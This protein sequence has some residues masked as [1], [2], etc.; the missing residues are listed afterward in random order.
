MAASV[1]QNLLDP[2][3]LH[4][5]EDYSL[6][7]RVVV[8]GAMPGIHRSLRQGRGS[9]FYQYRP[10]TRGEDLK[11][12]DWKV[13]AKRDELVSKTFQEST[14]FTVCLVMDVSASMGYEGKRASCSKLRYASMLAA[15]FSYLAHRQGDRLGLFAYSDE[16]KEWIRPRAGSGQLNRIYSALH[17]LEAQGVNAH[18]FGWDRMVSGLPGR[19]MVVFLSDFLE[20]E[21][22]LAE[23]LRFSL[24]SRYETLCLQVLDPDEIDLP[25]ADAL[26]FAELEGNREVSTS[27]PAIREKY[28]NEMAGFVEDLDEKLSAVSAELETLITNQDLGY[29]LRRFLGMRNRK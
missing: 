17:G 29:A 6:L 13:F 3:H 4:R 27:P 18:D 15:C 24:S 20:A 26:R 9:E 21:D 10:Y 25:E 7:A 8:D 5:I 16:V 19:A 23:K 1:D 28:K 2:A 14:N 11:L 22:S 12:V